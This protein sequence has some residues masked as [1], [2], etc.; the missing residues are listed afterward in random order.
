[1]NICGKFQLKFFHRYE[2]IASHRKGA[3]GWTTDGR[4]DYHKTQCVSRGFFDCGGIAKQS[5]IK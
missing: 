4:P 1:M 2:D 5:Q 3:N